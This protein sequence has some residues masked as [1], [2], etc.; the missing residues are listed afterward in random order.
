MMLPDQYIII[1]HIVIK[2]EPFHTVIINIKLLLFL[3]KEPYHAVIISITL[4]LLLLKEPNHT[5]IINITFLLLQITDMGDI[6]YHCFYTGHY[7]S[8]KDLILNFT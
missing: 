3:L 1:L 8:Q 6:I 4:L 7:C 5:V 2:K